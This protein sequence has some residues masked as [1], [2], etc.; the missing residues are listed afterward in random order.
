[1][2]QHPRAPSV[3]PSKPTDQSA[4]A[5]VAELH[6]AA[7]AGD[8]M[9][10][11]RLLA[12]GAPVDAVDAQGNSALLLATD[13][14][15]T[16]AAQALIAAGANVN[17]KNRQHD[18]AYLLAGARGYTDIVRLTLAAD[19]D[20]RSVNRFGGT[21]LIPACER[22]HVETVR[23]LAHT[24]DYPIDHI[25]RLGWT[26]LLEAVIL[27]DGSQP[28]QE[29]VQILKDAGA[30]MDIPDSDGITSLQHAER[31]GFKSIVKILR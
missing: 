16:A 5:L 29:I 7:R 6:A 22:G 15:R 19:A 12:A 31:K 13:G 8:A 25:N 9:R 14:H 4:T 2:A 20:L 17:L 28:Y 26:A 27:G 24:K 3:A 30:K 23:L 18:S 21:A 1:M 11:Q 10:V